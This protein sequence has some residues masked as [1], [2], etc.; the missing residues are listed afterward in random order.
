MLF[1]TLK[2][3]KIIAFKAKNEIKKNLLACL[4]ADSSKE[5]KEPSDDRVINTIRKYL[6]GLESN[7]Q[8]PNL[9][10]EQKSQFIEEIDILM[11]Y[12]PSQMS[13]EEIKKEIN[14]AFEH[15]VNTKP[16]IMGW[17]KNQFYC[18][19]DPKLLAQIID[20]IL[21]DKT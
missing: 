2:K 20:S 7:I 9:T 5:K 12:L 3:D 1:Q 18:R 11:S 13:E 14:F 8:L 6:S 15:E 21:E 4:I 10:D 16:L 19:Y 17:F